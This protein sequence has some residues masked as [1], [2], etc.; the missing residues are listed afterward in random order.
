[1]EPAQLISQ[2][3]VEPSILSADYAR[4]GEQIAT[5]MEAGARG[6]HVDVMDGHF[7][8]PITIGTVI[9][10]AIRDQVHETGGMLDC[11]LM[12]ERPEQQVAEF[13]KAGADSITIQIEATPN[14][15]YVLMQI[16]E[17][18]CL[19][20][21]AINPGT[22]PEAVSSV[23][24]VVDLVLCMTVNPGWGGQAFIERSPEKVRQLRKVLGPGIPIQVD[25]GISA[26][27]APSVKREGASLFVSGSQ[28]FHADDPAAA[29]REIAEVVA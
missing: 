5:V 24:D 27:T 4:L 7:V 8:P 23:V 12:I 15:H 1:M 13:A 20:G 11:H 26:E 9:V 2:K 3:L 6:I 22:P 25:G 19:A 10:E 17:H 21:V 28:I 14:V 29:Y 16:R 18:G